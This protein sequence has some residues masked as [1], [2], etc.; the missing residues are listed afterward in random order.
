MAF[1]DYADLVR[2][3][4]DWQTS[5]AGIL[6]LA[7][8]VLAYRAGVRQAKETRDAA[9]RQI[10]ALQ[11]QNA[12]L[13]RAEQRRLAQESLNAAR[14]LYASMGS[15][16]GVISSVRS[17]L[18]D[19]PDGLINEQAA[20]TLRSMIEKYN[21]DYLR[22]KVGNF[23]NEGLV[24]GF[25][26]LERSIDQLRA[27]KGAIHSGQ[28]MAELDNLWKQVKDLQTNTL[29]E[30]ERAKTVLSGDELPTHQGWP[31]LDDQ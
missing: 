15:V 28:F 9:D 16:A 23:D 27:Q 11:E 24:I 6:A 1:D 14:V 4:Y 10:L 17:A 18:I 30:F 22:E 29:E 20:N 31:N 12:D 19:N 3:V 7:G 13:K 21:F 25:Q 5:I 26:V 8:G 2:F